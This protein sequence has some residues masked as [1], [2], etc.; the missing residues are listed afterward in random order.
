MKIGRR[1]RNLSKM[2]AYQLSQEK[3]S[4]EGGRH[5]NNH[6]FGWLYISKGKHQH[7]QLSFQRWSRDPLIHPAAGPCT[8]QVGYSTALHC[9]VPIDIMAGRS[10]YQQVHGADRTQNVPK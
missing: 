4:S 1:L 2:Q 5:E 9:P 10:Q 3:N 8:K 6:V 7:S